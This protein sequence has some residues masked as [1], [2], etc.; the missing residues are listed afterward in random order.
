VS[1]AEITG[2]ESYVHLDA[3]DHRFVAL[4]PGVRRLEPK[5]P[6]TAYLNQRRLFLF[7]AEGRLAAI[8]PA[9]KAA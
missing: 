2:S 9:Q 5:T 3:G 6:V 1:V 7:D 8:D 4:V